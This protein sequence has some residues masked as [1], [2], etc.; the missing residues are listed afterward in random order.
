MAYTARGRRRIEERA[1]GPLRC[2]A[3]LPL[4]LR[5]RRRWIWRM[6]GYGWMTRI[7]SRCHVGPVIRIEFAYS[8]SIPIKRQVLTIFFFLKDPVIPACINK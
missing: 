7:K 8:I 1:V 3:L 2:V 6:D 5:L 4:L